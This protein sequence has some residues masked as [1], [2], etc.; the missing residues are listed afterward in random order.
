MLFLRGFR[1]GPCNPGVLRFYIIPSDSKS[2]PVFSIFC[3][4][5]F[6]WFSLMKQIIVYSLLF[7]LKT[8]GT[9]RFVSQKPGILR[10]FTAKLSKN[11]IKRRFHP[12]D[13]N[14][15]KQNALLRPAKA[16]LMFASTNRIVISYAELYSGT[17]AVRS[18]FRRFRETAF[19][20]Y[21]E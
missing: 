7:L 5:S 15:V 18:C 10:R 6:C 2:Q 9:D 14:S 17:R 19:L 4:F 8:Q 11:V 16:N 13:M 21:V 3:K 1:Y 20:L 12:A